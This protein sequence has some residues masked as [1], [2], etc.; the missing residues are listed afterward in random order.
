MGFDAAQ[1]GLLSPLSFAQSRSEVLI[2]AHI[3]TTTTCHSVSILHNQT[4]APKLKCA[5]MKF[6]NLSA[7]TSER[8]SLPLVLDRRSPRA[9]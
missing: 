7:S 8:V 9:P 2:V 3:E 5:S 6:T 1:S 4:L